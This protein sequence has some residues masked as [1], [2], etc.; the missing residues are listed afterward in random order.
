MSLPK[1]KRVKHISPAG[2]KVFEED[3]EWKFLQYVVPKLVSPA[4]SRSP[5]C[6]QSFGSVYPAYNLVSHSALSAG[7][8]CCCFSSG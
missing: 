7:S 5:C 1:S 8:C 2:E 4:P 3:E 6:Q